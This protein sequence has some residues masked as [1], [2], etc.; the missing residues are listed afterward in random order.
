MFS[1]IPNLPTDNLYKF[2]ALSG[3]ALMLASSFFMESNFSQARELANRIQ[4]GNEYFDLLSG[5]PDPQ[6]EELITIQKSQYE[7]LGELKTISETTASNMNVISFL[8]ALG[9]GMSIIGFWSWYILVQRPL[10]E[11]MQITLKEARAQKTKRVPFKVKID[12]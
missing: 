3:I 2:L 7:K 1:N 11:I 6:L 10:D 8:F 12:K 5:L 9:M 4:A